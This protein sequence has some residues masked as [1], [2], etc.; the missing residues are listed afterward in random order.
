VRLL[1]LRVAAVLFAVSWLVLPGFG[2]AD[3]MVSWDPD[4]PVVLEAGWGLFMTVLVAG[5]FLTVAVRPRDVTVPGVI[6]AV[7]LATWIGS[8]V[9][10]QEEE[11]LGFAGLL[12]A[13]AAVVAVLAGRG[14]L[15]P[16][17]WSVS[18]P[19]LA[20]ALAAVGPWVLYA[21]DM[22]RLNRFNVFEAVGDITMGID[23][24]AVQGALAVALVL[25]AGLA[26]CW[27]RGRRHLGLGGGLVAGYLG[28]VSLTHPGYEA[29]LGTPWSALAI[30]WGVV[31]A[32]LAVPAPRLQPGEFRGEVVEAERAL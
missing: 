19:L 1:A 8:A 28:L 13:E 29:A 4:W 18:V 24:Y 23:H 22:Y 20:V 7:T 2:L 6:L 9:A 27:P 11:L 21:V 14:R 15:Q 31:V 3:L 10:G 17:Q 12:A 16:P 5:S 25:L 30:A 26:A 32:V